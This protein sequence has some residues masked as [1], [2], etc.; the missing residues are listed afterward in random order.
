MDLLDRLLTWE[1]FIASVILALF[2]VLFF[3]IFGP[4]HKER[5]LSLYKE[6]IGIEN[7]DKTICKRILK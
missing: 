7:I 6:C 3:V 2:I 4:S 1:G 5:T